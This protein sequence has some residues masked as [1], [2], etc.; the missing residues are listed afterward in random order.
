MKY[1]ADTCIKCQETANGKCN[2]KGCFLGVQW[3]LFIDSPDNS[4]GAKN[5]KHTKKKKGKEYI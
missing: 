5:Y 4:F 1:G 3:L 2:K